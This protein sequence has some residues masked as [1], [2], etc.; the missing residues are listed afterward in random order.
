MHVAENFQSLGFVSSGQS[1][2]RNLQPMTSSRAFV[3]FD[4][5]SEQNDSIGQPRCYPVGDKVS[6]VGHP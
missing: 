3:V 2:Y 6:N 5:H 1:I 4:R